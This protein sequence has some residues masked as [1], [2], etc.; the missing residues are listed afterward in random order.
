MDCWLELS[1]ALW[2]VQVRSFHNTNPIGEL[3]Y[4]DWTY[5]MRDRI[6][7]SLPD[8]HIQESILWLLLLG[9]C[10]IYAGSL[11][12]SLVQQSSRGTA[13]LWARSSAI[14]RLRLVCLGFG[15]RGNQYVRSWG[16][17]DLS[18]RLL[19]YLDGCPGHWIPF[20][21]YWLSYVLGQYS[22]FL[23]RCT[24]YWESRRSSSDSWSLYSVLVCLKMGGVSALDLLCYLALF[25][26]G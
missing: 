5:S 9:C 3:C 19:W 16:D 1:L 21:C 23:S 20:Q 24:L 12:W 2:H 14:G 13:I 8:S 18:G 11:S 25:Q 4:T 15:S 17:G 6:P 26:L 22:E 10:H 7:Q